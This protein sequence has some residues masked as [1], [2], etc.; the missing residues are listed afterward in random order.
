MSAELVGLREAV[1]ALALDAVGDV[2]LARGL[3]P[4]VRDGRVDPAELRIA[5][6]RAAAS[7]RA[8]AIYCEQHRDGGPDPGGRIALAEAR[9]GAVSG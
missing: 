1:R 3:E 8:L 2:D 4:L 5:W 7:F 6:D 9:Y